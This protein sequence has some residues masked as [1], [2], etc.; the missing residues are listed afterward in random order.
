[1][2]VSYKTKEINVL[3]IKEMVSDAYNVTVEELNSKKNKNIAFP[4]QVA[5][6]ISKNFA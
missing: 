1:M 2:L 6:Y 4:R 3:R 5:M